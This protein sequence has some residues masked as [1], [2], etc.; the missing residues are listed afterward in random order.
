MWFLSGVSCCFPLL[1]LSLPVSRP[2]QS[3]SAASP[4]TLVLLPLFKL[5]HPSLPLPSHSP[6]IQSLLPRLT[7]ETLSLSI[8]PSLSQCL[9]LALPPY[10]MP[11]SFF[12]WWL[13]PS[14]V[15]IRALP[16]YNM[17]LFSL[18]DK[19]GIWSE[20]YGVRLT[21]MRLRGGNLCLE[22]A[23]LRWPHRSQRERPETIQK[24]VS[25]AEHIQSGLARH[26]YWFLVNRGSQA[27][28]SSGA[29]LAR[30]KKKKPQK[31]KKQQLYYPGGKPIEWSWVCTL[32]GFFSPPQTTAVV[33][34]VSKGI[35]LLICPSRAFQL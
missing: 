3:C 14:C 18:A 11:L 22:P 12:P 2:Q 23:T 32:C 29:E 27:S 30:A 13:T 21:E 7:P 8:S 9:S 20:G 4:E 6:I 16:L 35:G 19:G 17:F 15:I 25:L 24:P 26:R 5:M 33:Y 1:S 28:F 34:L 10:A 31:P